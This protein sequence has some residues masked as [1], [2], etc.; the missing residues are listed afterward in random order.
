M[1]IAVYGKVKAARLGSSQSLCA[2]VGKET[3]GKPLST[4]V[5]KAVGCAEDKTLQ[6]LY[7]VLSGEQK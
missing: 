1:E 6:M 5:G 3:P 2:I 7:Q 4:G